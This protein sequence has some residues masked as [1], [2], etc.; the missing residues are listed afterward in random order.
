VGINA[1]RGIEWSSLLRGIGK[2]SGKEK[3]PSE[4]SARCTE[5]I[6]RSNKVN[7]KI[8]KKKR[9]EGDPFGGGKERPGVSQWAGKT[10]KKQNENESIQ[11]EISNPRGKKPDVHKKCGRKRQEQWQTQARNSEKMEKGGECWEWGLKLAG[12]ISNQNA[13]RGGRQREWEQTDSQP[14]TKREKRKGA[15]RGKGEHWVQ[16]GME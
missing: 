4:N 2:G 8:T 6:Q 13:S 7:F 10:R 11:K 16:G 12:T 5:T 15:G 9:G 1:N 14:K 3:P